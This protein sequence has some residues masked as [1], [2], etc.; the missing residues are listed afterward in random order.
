[1]LPV[2]SLVNEVAVPVIADVVALCFRSE[3]VEYSTWYDFAP[4]TDV[5]VTFSAV[6]EVRV[7]LTDRVGTAA[8]ADVVVSPSATI[9][10]TPSTATSP[11]ARR[12]AVVVALV[13]TQKPHC[14]R[15]VGA[16][17]INS[18]GS[19]PRSGCIG[20]IQLSRPTIRPETD[21][22]AA[23]GVVELDKRLSQ[24]SSDRY[25]SA[26]RGCR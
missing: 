1:M 16:E 9:A 17:P 7:G 24:T 3:R 4:G 14:R 11:R 26:G 10:S 18:L 15:Y 8:E 13:T 22:V 21:S 23:K 19:W 6:A 25:G 12:G 2:S 20:T 5:Q